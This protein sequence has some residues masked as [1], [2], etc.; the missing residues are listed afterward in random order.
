MMQV[1]TDIMA[2]KKPRTT[3][4]EEFN[5]KVEEVEEV[6]KDKN[7]ASLILFRLFRLRGKKLFGNGGSKR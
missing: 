1:M 5:R 3:R 2:R 6:F 4:T 7:T